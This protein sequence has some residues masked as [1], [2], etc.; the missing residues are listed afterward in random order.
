MAGTSLMPVML[1]HGQHRGEL[2]AAGRQTAAVLVG[3]KSKFQGVI[4]R[5]SAACPQG[6]P[7]PPSHQHSW[8]PG[9]LFWSCGK[10]T[11]APNFSGLA[12]LRGSKARQTHEADSKRRH[13]G[14]HDNEGKGWLLIRRAEQRDKSFRQPTQFSSSYRK[15]TEH[16]G[17]LNWHP[18]MRI[19][20][21]TFS[22]CFSL[23][24][25]CSVQIILDASQNPATK[26]EW[27]T[28]HWTPLNAFRSQGT[29]PC[30]LGVI[31]IWQDL[32]STRLRITSC[33]SESP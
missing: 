4:K 31:S 26:S 10:T 8:A 23:Q 18:R 5:T 1:S 14:N 33:I 30:P 22:T 21:M 2:G 25:P 15:M 16:Q 12:T 32:A 3:S 11:L 9:F 24:M 19:P 7:G 29:E 6:P 20:N 13:L 27:L 17:G 28:F